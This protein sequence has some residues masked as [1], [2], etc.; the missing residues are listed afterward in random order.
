MRKEPAC[1]HLVPTIWDAALDTD[2]TLKSVR[3]KPI[4]KITPNSFFTT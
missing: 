2:E 3:D 4:P 1:T